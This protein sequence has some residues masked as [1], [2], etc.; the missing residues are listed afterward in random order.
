MQTKFRLGARWMCFVVLLVATAFRLASEPGVRARVLALRAREDEPVTEALA[1]M[2]TYPTLYYI[3]PEEASPDAA[4][5]TIDNRSGL[6]VDPAA[7][8]QTSLPLDPQVDGPVV[9]ILHTHATEAYAGTEGYRTEDTSQNVVR[10]GQALA[11]ALNARGIRTI[12]DTTLIDQAGYNDA[13]PRMAEIAADYLARYPTLQMVIDV[14]RDALETEDGTQLPVTAQV[15]GEDCARM[16]LV[17]GTDA[18]GQEH[19]DWRTNLACAVRL[20]A[21]CEQRWPGLFR[22]LSLRSQRYNQHLTRCSLL[23]EVGT[24]GNTLAQALRSA[25]LLAQALEALFQGGTEVE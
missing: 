1:T 16:M 13:Y 23:V 4:Q 6:E 12:H 14:H 19:P 5:V 7:L 10:V 22:D 11:D 8:A 17:M 2:S 18:S 9:L 24:A 25:D 3:P 15:E 21:L 20:Q